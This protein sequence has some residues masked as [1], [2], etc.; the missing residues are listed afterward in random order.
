MV[1]EQVLLEQVELLMN[2]ITAPD[3]WLGVELRHLAALDAVARAGS[4][5]RAADALG[6]T[7]SAISQ[8]I[9]TL[10][11]IVGERLVERPGGPR[12]VSLTEAGELL[13]RHA[14]AIVARFDAAQADMAALHAGETGALRIG[15]YQSVGARVLPAVMRRFLADWPRIEISLGE[16]TTDEEL[17]E[18]IENGTVDLAFGSPPLTEGP[19]ETQILLRDPW[20]LVVPADG[21]LARRRSAN[22]A[23]L[24]DVRL[25]GSNQCAS[26]TAF[27]AGLAEQG[28]EVEY[29]FRSD[30]N[31]TLQGMAAAGFGVALMPLLAVSPGDERVKVLHLDPSIPQREIAVVWHRDRHRSPAARAFVDLAVEVG[32]QVEQELALP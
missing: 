9:A 22:L 8:Q 27:E 28:V 3:K 6:Y 25:L 31:G 18:G 4:F 12:R 5:G 26:G 7:Q 2:T 19:F 21:P 16:S 29:A 1:A 17:Y 30:D 32:A 23:D 15:T 14:E 24:E 13:R 10:E 11:R 20:V